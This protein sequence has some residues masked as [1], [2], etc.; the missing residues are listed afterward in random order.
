MLE[1][2]EILGKNISFEIRGRHKKIICRQ[3]KKPIFPSFTKETISEREVEFSD[4][5][6]LCE[7]L[8][9]LKMAYLGHT[10]D[11]HG[12]EVYEKCGCHYIDKN[13][14]A[15]CEQHMEEVVR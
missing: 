14:I 15:I 6:V 9:C 12:W 8:Q 11:F 10:K 13:D 5:D 3:Y 7:I 1:E 2:I 4:L